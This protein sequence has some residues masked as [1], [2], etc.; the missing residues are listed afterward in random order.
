MTTVSDNSFFGAFAGAANT[1]GANNAFFGSN[2]G[3]ANQNGG[4]NSFF[5]AVAG[6]NNTTGGFNSFFG[7][8]AGV[9]NTTGDRNAFFGNSAGNSNVVGSLITAIGSNADVGVNNLVNATAIG[10]RAQVDQS[11]SLVLGSI[12]GVNDATATVSVG[13][14]TTTPSE[15]LHVVGNALVTGTLTV[16]SFGAGGILN[17]CRNT[18]SQ[19][20]TCSS[21]LRYKDHLAPFTAGLEVINRLR[22]ITFT[23]K[24]GGVRDLGLGAEDVARVEP[25]LVTYN[26][27]GQVEGVKYDRFAVVLINAVREQQEL[28]KQQQAQIDELKKLACKANPKARLCR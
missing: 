13:I 3:G 1:G 27:R 24:Q 9:V 14:G 18:S 2:A 7:H 19:L 26:E 28:I 17:V 8:G 4:A 23:W 21:S 10:A 16:N 20:A 25:L 5:G 11:N 12:S 22:P 6:Q 15:R